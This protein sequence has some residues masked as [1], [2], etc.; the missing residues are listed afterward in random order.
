M[1]S[2]IPLKGASSFRD[3]VKS[4]AV[5]PDGIMRSVYLKD[6]GLLLGVEEQVL[7]TEVNKIRQQKQEQQLAQGAEFI[8]TARDEPGQFRPALQNNPLFLPSWRIFFPRWKSGKL[9]ISC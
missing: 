8:G 6:C 1:L 5:I 2:M 7:Y 9:F 3:I 4:V